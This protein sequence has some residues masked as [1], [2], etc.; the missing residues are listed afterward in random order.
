MGRG[1]EG[2]LWAP[3]AWSTEPPLPPHVLRHQSVLPSGARGTRAPRR[4]RRD[5]PARTTKVQPG[6]TGPD[7]QSHAAGGDQGPNGMARPS[8]P[9]VGSLAAPRVAS[10]T[11]LPGAA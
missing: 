10:D 11:A 6:I 8:A 7:P 4:C 1:R 5:L 3:A 2:A 9:G